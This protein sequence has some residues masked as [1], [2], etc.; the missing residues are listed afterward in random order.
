MT[1]QTIGPFFAMYVVLVGLMLGSFIN[2]AADRIPRGESIVRPASHCQACGRSLNVVDLLPVA[3]YLVRGGRCASCKAPIAASAPLIE[4]L[5]G[6]LV[7]ASI[8]ELGI[9]WGAALGLCL[10]AGTGFA[11][12]GLAMRQAGEPESVR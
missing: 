8:G 10:V 3:G 11:I 4:L 12:V 5:C 7:V 1:W 2:L 9:G 6:L